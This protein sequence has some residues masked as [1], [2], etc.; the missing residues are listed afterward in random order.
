MTEVPPVYLH[1]R[2]QKNYIPPDWRHGDLMIVMDVDNNAYYCP[3]SIL[4]QCRQTKDC[5]SDFKCR[6]EKN[7]N[8]VKKKQNKRYKK[9]QERG[10]RVSSGEDEARQAEDHGQG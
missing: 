8:Q 7:K 4:C 5:H 10:P 2:A 9:V 6:H 1:Q 3:P